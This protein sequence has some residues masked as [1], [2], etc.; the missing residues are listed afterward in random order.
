[1]SWLDT[2]C[3]SHTA[4]LG[5]DRDCTGKPENYAKDVVYL[6]P[7][8]REEGC[9]QHD[10]QRP[11]IGDQTCLNRWCALDREKVG[12]MVDTQASGSER[13]YL[14]GWRNDLIAVGLNIQLEAPDKPSKQERH[15]RKLE[16][17]NWSGSCRQQRQKRPGQDG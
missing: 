4:A 12:A 7:L 16:R 15:R 13:P 1:M 10:Q 2:V 6:Q 8:A 9:E 3:Q 14:Q 11:K 17:G 5:Y